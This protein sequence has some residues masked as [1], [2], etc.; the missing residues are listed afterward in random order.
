MSSEQQSTAH[1]SWPG[2]STMMSLAEKGA[3]YDELRIEYEKLKVELDAKTRVLEEMTKHSPN[4][5]RYDYMTLARVTLE[6]FRKDD[7]N[8][9]SGNPDQQNSD[10]PSTP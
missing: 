8:G 10:L 3:R 1:A 4:R 6:Q 9:G 2:L 7:A 5:Q